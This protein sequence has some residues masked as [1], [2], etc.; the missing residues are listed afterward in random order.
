MS[1][2]GAAGAAEDVAA[3][4]D[5]L[6]IGEVAERI[7]LSLRTIRFYEEEGLVVPDARSAGGFRLYTD[8]AL[9]RLGLIK[10]MKP[11]GFSVEEMREILGHLDEL[12]SEAPDAERRAELVRTLDG[13]RAVV[14]ERAAD[15]VAKAARGR[16]LGRH[17]CD[18]ADA[19]R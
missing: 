5:L 19:H 1:E 4:R 6:K 18:V 16:E 12:G 15:L 17:L 7:G 10:R 3:G 14:E 8:D 11:L 2:V 9:T 13:V